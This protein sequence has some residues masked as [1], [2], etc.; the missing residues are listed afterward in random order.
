VEQALRVAVYLVLGF[1]AHGAVMKWYYRWRL[2]RVRAE[3]AALEEATRVKLIDNYTH[4]SRLRI[5]QK[6]AQRLQ[7]RLDPSGEKT[8]PGRQDE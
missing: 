3:I 2:R 1:F 4:H 5:L 6:I 8:I 7:E